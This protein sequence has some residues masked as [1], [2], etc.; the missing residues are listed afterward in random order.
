MHKAILKEIESHK[1]LERGKFLAGFFKT[2]KGQYGEGDIFW[3]L[4]VPA[5]RHIAA[6]YKEMSLSDIEKLIKHKVHEVR[7]IGLIILVSKYQ[8]GSAADKKKIVSFYI[9]NAKRVNNWDLVDSSAHQILGEY[10][11]Y[12]KDRKILI[13]LAKSKNLWEQ[14]IAIVSTYAFIRKGE[15][16]YTFK[17]TEMLMDHKHDLIHKAAGWML[18]EVGKKAGEVYLRRFLDKH[19]HRMPRTML[20]YSIERFPVPLRLSYLKKKA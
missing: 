14:R 1:D 9:K 13:K 12:K 10:L 7:F 19:A 15:S 3:G 11:L 16:E 8:R 6:K 4:S 17:V 2:G 18:R 20:R 5:S